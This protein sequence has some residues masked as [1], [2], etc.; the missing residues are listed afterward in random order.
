MF[1]WV[2]DLLVKPSVVLISGPTTDAINSGLTNKSLT[3]N[4]PDQ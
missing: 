3:I 4:S 2:S 1:F